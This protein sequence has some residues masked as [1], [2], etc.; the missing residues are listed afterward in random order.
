MGYTII[1][2]LSVCT[3]RLRCIRIL[4]VSL[5]TV[6]MTQSDAAVKNTCN[7]VFAYKLIVIQV[8]Y[9]VVSCLCQQW[10]VHEQSDCA[11]VFITVTVLLNGQS[12]GSVQDESASVI[13]CVYKTWLPDHHYRL[14]TFIRCWE[15]D[16]WVCV[17]LTHRHT[18]VLCFSSR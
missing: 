14:V 6:Q 13:D 16:C 15:H 17:L 1:L 7:P 9:R 2:H 11:T 12:Q 5:V 3:G 4:S 18:L 10:T 8:P